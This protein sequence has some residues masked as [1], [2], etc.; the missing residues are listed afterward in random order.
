MKKPITA[1]VAA[2]ALGLAMVTTT[3]PARAMNPWTAAAWFVGGMFTAAV[4]APAFRPAYAYAGGPAYAYAG[5]GYGYGYGPTYASWSGGADC[6]TTRVRRGGVWR[7]AR[8][9]IQ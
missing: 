8:V 5:T 2:G 4:L 6:Y 1:L 7:N 3:Q 9:C